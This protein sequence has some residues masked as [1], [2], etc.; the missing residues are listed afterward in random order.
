MNNKYHHLNEYHCL[1]AQ[2]KFK[3]IQLISQSMIDQFGGV[4]KVKKW[5]TLEHNG[6]MF[7]PEY[8]PHN[9]PILYGNDKKML[10][11]NPEA[12]E[13]ATYYVQS[14][15]DKYR[16]EKFKKN[17][18]KDWSKLLTPE[19]KNIIIDFDLCNFDDIKNEAEK[20]KNM[21]NEDKKI[22]TDDN[23]KYKYAIVDG[24]KQMIDNFIVEPPTIFVGR[25]SH[26]LSGSI[27]SRIY[28]EEITLNIGPNMNIPMP[29][30][31]NQKSDLLHQWGKIISDNTLEWIA[32]WQNNVTQKYNYARFGRKS[33]FKMKSDENKYDLARKLKKKIKKI[34]IQN[35][36]NMASSDKEMKQLS[37]ALFLI[38]KLALRIGNEKKEDEA[39]TTGVTTLKI[40]NITLLSDTD[41]LI[42]LDFLGKDSI[43]YVNKI[44]VPD[45]VYNNISE[46]YQNKA[47]DD[48]LFDLITSDTL[49][50]YIKHFMKKLTSKVFR[51]YNASYLMQ[52]ELKKIIKSMNN[53]DKND[54]ITKIKHLYDM[55]NLKVAKL[56][57]HQREATK[58]S[59]VM[60]QKTL[61][62]IEIIKN[63]INKLKKKKK[64]LWPLIK[65]LQIYKQ[66]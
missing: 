9:V 5:N 38:D 37:T 43:R 26:P 46:F 14:R 20:K 16:N 50:K 45:T 59:G 65:K 6:V 34:R 32:S 29:V 54:K 15:F 4:K 27:K 56:C 7:Y 10:I 61:D 63:K 18:F 58:S 64:K 28:P 35:E 11:L 62:K 13:F 39:N 31:P 51:T 19:L 49:N 3:Y 17:F 22:K 47:K 52:I 30:I 23:E 53:Y 48:D 55:A 1:Y 36:I 66:N 25:G 33:I 57:N 21:A 42:K 44:K 41:K 8:E 24:T 2:N 40:K 12:E 60:I